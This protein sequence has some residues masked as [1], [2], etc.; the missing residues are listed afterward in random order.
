MFKESTINTLSGLIGSIYDCALDPEIWSETLGNIAARLGCEK[1]LLSLDDLHQSRN[2]I[3][4]SFGW[5]PRWLDERRKHLCEIHCV[6]NSW[7][8][9]KRDGDEP[10]VASQVLSP[11]DAEQSSYVQYCLAPQGITD[12]AHFFLARSEQTL[13]ELVLFRHLSRGN[14]VDNEIDLGKLLLPH[15]RRAIAISRLLDVKAVAA[16]TFENVLDTLS[17]AVILVTSELELVHANRAADALLSRGDPIA[18]RKN[19]LILS[20]TGATRALA[21]AVSQAELDE[22]RIGFKSLG[23]PVNNCSGQR[24][25]LHV[26]PLR[27]GHLRS[28]LMPKAAAAIFVAPAAHALLTSKAALA[29]LFDLTPTETAVL[30]RILAGDAISDVAYTLGVTM[31]TIKTHMQHIFDKTGVRRQADLIALM[32]SFALPLQV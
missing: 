2:L 29:T 5:E 11:Q 28:E 9:A 30:D 31:A 12:V 3:H 22:A 18:L 26:L 21:D 10:F 8:S 17:A 20:T 25:L 23:I 14:F 6:L 19:A 16:E 27:Q 24:S 4:R 7:S 13:S 15:L 32:A 1:A